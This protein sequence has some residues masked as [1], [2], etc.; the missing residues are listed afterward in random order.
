M[1]TVYSQADKILNILGDHN[2]KSLAAVPSD[3]AGRWRGGGQSGGGGRC[4]ALQAEDGDG[5]D[6]GLRL[7]LQ[8][9]GSGRRLLDEGGVLLRHGIHV[10]DG[11][12]DL[13]DAVHRIGRECVNTACLG[14]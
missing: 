9:F 7:F 14:R 13:A 2:L 5:L 8:A 3:V 10:R 12:I 11:R 6:Q 4:A 1:M